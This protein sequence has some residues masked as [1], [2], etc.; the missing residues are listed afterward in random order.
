MKQIPTIFFLLFAATVQA[1]F[2][3]FLNDSLGSGAKNTSI[4]NIDAIYVINLDQRVDKLQKVNNQFTPYGIQPYR[5]PA[6][7]GWN[8]SNQL[9]NQLGLLY[10]KG[11]VM[12]KWVNFYPPE[13]NLSLKTLLDEE[14]YGKRCL[15]KSATLG[16][17][18]RLLS[19]LSILQNALNQN[20]ETIWIIEDDISLQSDPHRLSGYIGKLD[21]LTRKD[22]DIL[23]TDLDND[24]VAN[25]KANCLWRPDFSTTS[26]E[27][28][29]S[30]H[31]L[32][33]DFIQVSSKKKTTSML[34]RRSGVKK[35]LD[36]EKKHSLFNSWEDELSIIPHLTM[37]SMQESLTK[38]NG[39]ISDTK[40]NCFGENISWNNHREAILKLIPSL[41]G[42]H[43][44]IANKLM[45]FVQEKKPTRIVE[46]SNSDL[47][48]PFCIAKTLQ[49]QKEGTL[50]S[51]LPE[52]SREDG[53]LLNF[54]LQN[55]LEKY[56]EIK[57]DPSELKDI[58][59]DLLILN[60]PG[61]SCAKQLDRFLL[62]V[63]PGGYICLN[64]AF[65][66][67]KHQD[68]LHLLQ[69]CAWLKEDSIKSDCALFQK[70]YNDK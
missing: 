39:G 70:N 22:W 33:Q 45:N 49:F 24:Y 16:D 27:K 50:I 38:E 56:W 54:L 11:M 47:T 12:G 26:L 48:L 4:A 64:H 68:I 18:G 9:L 62:K 5:F 17:I 31:P 30:Y 44:T 21:S 53:N 67:I 7:Y 41:V 2:T 1:N 15:S 20:Y 65:D 3:A 51:I 35:V 37:F 55:K 61:V 46:C 34:M 6:I 59:I 63:K 69:T 58:A 52:S 14:F 42:S 43:H 66:P 40:T 8:L 60:V 19:Y 29:P 32:N 23:F 10:Q 13:G 25:Q 36:Y 28:K 57:K